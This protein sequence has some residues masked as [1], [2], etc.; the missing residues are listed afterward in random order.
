M[1]RS[2]NVK[3]GT[4]DLSEPNYSPYDDKQLYRHKTE[5]QQSNT[6]LV[7]S[8]SVFCSRCQ[9]SRSLSWS[10]FD[11]ACGS[12]PFVRTNTRIE[13]FSIRSFA[14]A[15]RCLIHLPCVSWMGYF[16]AL[17]SHCVRHAG[18]VLHLW[19]MLFSVLP[20]CPCLSGL[21]HPSPSCTSGD[22]A[23][24]WFLKECGFWYK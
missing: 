12:A 16:G 11:E 13:L 8:P 15:V 22:R 18:Y 19:H 23:I 24:A 17:L 14:T 6:G 21:C 20:G 2:P 3:T 1:F 7:C 5:Q 10:L 4:E 9:F